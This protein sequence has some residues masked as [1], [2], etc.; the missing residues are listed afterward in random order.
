MT[1]QTQYNKKGSRQT[2]EGTHK[3]R[4]TRLPA[5]SIKVKGPRGSTEGLLAIVAL[6]PAP[7][8]YYRRKEVMKM[9]TISKDAVAVELGDDEHYHVDC[10]TANDWKRCSTEDHKEI[11]RDY[12]H[13][14][15][16]GLKCNSCG[17]DI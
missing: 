6:S 5:K 7:L 16:Y 12:L 15:E 4:A 17:E 10:M 1:E 2:L 3:V 14:M 9:T 8:F 13:E 11:D